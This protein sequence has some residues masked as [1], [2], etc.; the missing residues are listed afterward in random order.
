MCIRLCDTYQAQDFDEEFLES[1]P[2]DVRADLLKKKTKQ[3]ELEEDRYR[4]P[5]SY[6]EKEDYRKQI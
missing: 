5:S 3:E 6:I 4:R 2:E 1:L